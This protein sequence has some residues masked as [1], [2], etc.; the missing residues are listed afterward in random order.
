WEDHAV[1]FTMH[2]IL[3]DGWSL[4]LLAGEV[5]AFYTG[6]VSGHPAPLPELAVQYADFAWWQRQWLSGDVLAAEI[7]YWRRRLAGLPAVLELSTDRPRPRIQSSRGSLEK[8]PLPQDLNARLVGLA[9]KEGATLFMVLLAALQTLLSRLTGQ[10]DLAVGAPIS[11]RSRLETESLIGFF[12]NTLVLRGDLAGDPTFR[13]LLKR[14]REVVLGA[15]LHQHLPFEMIVQELGVERSLS[16]SPLFQ[17]MLALDNTKSS[18]LSLPDLTVEALEVESGVARFDLTVWVVEANGSLTGAL[19]YNTDLFDRTTILRVAR[20]FQALLQS[21]VETPAGRLSELPLLSAPERQQLFIEWNDTGVL[22][23]AECVPE[24]FAEQARHTPDAPALLAGDAVW[25]YRDLDRASDRMARFLRGL[26]V[27]PETLVGV[28]TERSPEM[29]VAL[30]GIL[31]AGGAYLPLD[32][33]Y[34]PER[35][36]FMLEDSGAAVLLTEERLIAGLPST[37]ARV[38]TL[39]RG[40]VEAHP[41]APLGERTDPASLAY[42]L[43]TSGSTGRPKGVQIPHG[44][45]ANLLASMRLRPG[46]AAGDRLLAVTS[47]SFDIAGLELFLPLTTGARID[48]ATRETILDGERLRDRLPVA[49][50][51]QATPSTWR[52]LLDAGWEGDRGFRALCGGEAL[53]PG[54]A[55][56]LAARTGAVWNLYGPTE[57]TVYSAGHR[58]SSTQDAAGAGI[59][60]IGRPIAETRIHVL[61]PALEPVPVGVPGDLYIG[62]AGLAR[63]YLGRPDLTAA[64]FVPDPFAGL[65]GSPPGTRLYRTGDL[66]RFLPDG[67]LAYLGRTDQQV[68]VRGFRIEI[69]EVEAVVA[70]CP[71]VR[72]VVAVVRGE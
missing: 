63:G 58:L 37:G 54:L 51:L 29:V 13:E 38:I 60:P 47:L 5:G 65:A 26:G 71:G 6:L 42:V 4:D 62:G 48:L 14:T 2:H 44:A 10:Q 20:H 49:T 68:K 16:H 50:V 18:A 12:V 69:G 57:T 33:S 28:A 3:S 70:Q 52:M 31:K 17:V 7:D 8:L 25:T 59:V 66:A 23:T 45:L 39:D 32:P 53:P 34:P 21:A 72:E 11:G 56:E 61:G 19:E 30:L 41:P 35:L 24:G 64:A 43:Y 27:G 67:A 1:L 22:E 36:R 55:G 46:L 40:R 15:D 9:R